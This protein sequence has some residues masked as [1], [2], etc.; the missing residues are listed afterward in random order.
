MSIESDY[1]NQY[2]G[3]T[4]EAY[5]RQTQMEN[6]R[7]MER[8]KR[9]AATLPA[10]TRSVLDIGCGGGIA[11]NEVRQRFNDHEIECVGLE[12]SELTAAAAR[13]LFGLKVVEGSADALP[14][15]DK[16]FDFVMANELLEHLTWATYQAA[17]KEIARVARHGI[18]ITTPFNERRQFVT[19]PKCNCAFSPFYHVRSF[20]DST[21]AGLF[22]GFS[23]IQQELIWV[24]GRTPLLYE[25]RRLKAALGYVPL[26]PKHTICPQCGYR[27][28]KAS[29]PA[30]SAKK[31]VTSA[32]GTPGTLNRL[33]TGMWG[34]LPRRKRPKWAI[35]VYSRLT[36]AA[37]A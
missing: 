17:L 13:N 20:D 34:R 8:A 7:Q 31:K 36:E 2:V 30:D 29:T 18:L 24:K 14:F 15:E 11:L 19:C 5:I 1:Y 16:S 32:D 21:L 25:A 12:R 28:P 23:R 10:N 27:N 22:E 26:L 9:I 4:P 35:V 33:V 6:P 37:G 3:M